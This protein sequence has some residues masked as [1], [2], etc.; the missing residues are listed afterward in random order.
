MT[1]DLRQILEK[2]ST[3]QGKV[4]PVYT[5]KGLNPQQ[6]SADQLPALFQPRKI[7]AL[8]SKTDPQHPMKGLAVGADE[9]KIP[10]A[11]LAET[12]VEVE[13]DMLSQVRRDL[14]MYLDTLADQESDDGRRDRRPIEIHKLGKKDKTD[15]DLVQKSKGSLS[16]IL[17]DVQSDISESPGTSPTKREFNITVA[18]S[19]YLGRQIQKVYT[20]SAKDAKT[21]KAI[22]LNNLAKMGMPNV[23]V[24]DI[25][26]RGSMNEAPMSKARQEV[27]AFRK[28]EALKDLKALAQPISLV[29]PGAGGA[30]KYTSDINKNPNIWRASDGSTVRVS[31]LSE[32]GEYLP[33]WLNELWQEVL[34]GEETVE[35]L[36]DQ[37]YLEAGGKELNEIFADRQ[38]ENF[39]D[40]RTADELNIGDDVI[41]TGNVKYQGATGIIDSFGRD[42][43]F[44][45]V[46]LYNHGKHSFHSSDVE[47]NDYADSDEEEERLYTRDPDYRR[48]RDANDDDDLREGVAET[49]D[50]FRRREREEAII[51]GQKPARKRKPAQTSDYARRKEQEKNKEQG[52]AESADRPMS[53]A[54]KTMAMEDGCVLEIHGDKNTGFEIRRGDRRMS[55]RF[56]DMDQA[57]VAVDLYRARQRER[58]RGEPTR[59]NQDYMEER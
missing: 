35:F 51:S 34:S 55:A 1:T 29:F 38:E 25:E 37:G 26:E 24:L 32:L 8:K 18:D 20:V 9:S 42:K 36:Q 7:S 40:G 12:M 6:K 13:E 47:G 46:N 49:S 53:R 19:D 17:A 22:L 41:I 58:N 23:E 11:S 39:G 33:K 2:L 4:T 43:R 31:S 14:T 28:Q 15:R 30:F 56:R 59:D 5:D 57:E 44:V 48:Y 21:A 3:I 10:R 16:E 50:Y 27:D 54:V 45:V 52:V